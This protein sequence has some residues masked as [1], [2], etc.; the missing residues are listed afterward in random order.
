ML[1]MQMRISADKSVG[2]QSYTVYYEESLILMVSLGQKQ[3]K[4]HIYVSTVKEALTATGR[5]T[6][7]QSTSDNRTYQQR[8]VL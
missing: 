8:T 1:I 7:F 3:N 2:L 6:L 5:T 4:H